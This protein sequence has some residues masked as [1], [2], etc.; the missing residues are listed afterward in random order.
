[1]L[2][3]NA[4][5]RS[6]SVPTVPDAAGVEALLSRL[7][8]QAATGAMTALLADPTVRGLLGRYTVAV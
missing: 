6:G 4:D 1:M 3:P 8:T 5:G 2:S 7:A